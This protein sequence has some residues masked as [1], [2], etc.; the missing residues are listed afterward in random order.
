MTQETPG[1]LLY[2]RRTILTKSTPE[3][4]PSFT[5]VD[6]GVSKA[7]YTV[8]KIIRHAGE[9][10]ADGEGAFRV[11]YIGERIDELAGLTPRALTCMRPR[12]LSGRGV[13]GVYQ[14]VS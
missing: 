11:S 5:D 8:H 2:V 3:T 4:S 10:I 12:L 7:G 9:V 13:G 6:M 1:V 14:Y